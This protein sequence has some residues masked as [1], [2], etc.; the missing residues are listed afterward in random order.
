M[1]V[2]G[3]SK[4]VIPIA[5][6]DWRPKPLEPHPEFFREHSVA[7]CEA[8]AGSIGVRCAAEDC[9]W[10]RRHLG[11]QRLERGDRAWP[12]ASAGRRIDRIGGKVFE[13]GNTEGVD[14]GLGENE[15]WEGLSRPR[16]AEE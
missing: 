11:Q 5:T 16:H 15:P 14:R 3:G 12:H 9:V 2:C 7:F 1:V 13:G 10:E 4:D 8:I 6:F